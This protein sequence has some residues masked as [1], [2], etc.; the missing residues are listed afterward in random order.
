MPGCNICLNNKKKA[1][2]ACVGSKC[3]LR[4]CNACRK[5]TREAQKA[6]NTRKGCPQCSKNTL[7]NA[8]AKLKK[9]KNAVK[10]LTKAHANVIKRTN[11]AMKAEPGYRRVYDAAHKAMKATTT[12]GLLLSIRL[13]NVNNARDKM[14][15]A[16]KR[17]KNLI[18]EI[19]IASNKL[20]N[21]VKAHRNFLTNQD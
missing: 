14:L 9:L 15:N 2:P 18:K 19:R 3:S 4:W 7:N 16:E 13:N 11:N 10:D 12:T 6:G 1:G 17:T 5:K 8:N 21:A 20:A